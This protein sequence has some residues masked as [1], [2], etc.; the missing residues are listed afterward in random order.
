[1][2]SLDLISNEFLFLHCVTNNE[3]ILSIDFKSIPTKICFVRELKNL[4]NLT[5]YSALWVRP[6]GHIA[7]IGHLNNPS[8]ITKLQ[9]I[10]FKIT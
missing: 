2:S 8:E 10:I 6:D 5:D 9:E 4:F 1:M 7:W 3:Y